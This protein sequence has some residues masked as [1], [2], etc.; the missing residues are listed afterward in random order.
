M[1]TQTGVY[2][3]VLGAD[4]SCYHGGKGRW[5]LAHDGQP[6][7]WLPRLDGTLKPCSYG[8]HVLRPEHLIEW[9]G[10]AIHRAEAEEPV[11][12]DADKGVTRRARDL[13]RILQ[14]NRET[15]LLFA[16]DVIEHIAGL[17]VAP[18]GVTWKPAD[19]VDVIRRFTMGETAKDEID[20]AAA[21][22]YVTA[23]A[24]DDDAAATIAYAAA[25][26]AHTAATIT[27]RAAATAAADAAIIAAT[28]ARA[29]DDAHSNER[30]WQTK[31]LC[32][33]LEIDP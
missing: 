21:A 26:A 10:P 20:A 30:R 28:A 3:K 11:A 29:A 18:K 33:Y 7:A 32:E 27:A 5:P 8:Y 6:G 14:W 12:W 25:V 23:R 2:Y 9:L 13:G 4:G 15:Q 22:A 16:A 1:T 31:R 24:A 19:T 17:W